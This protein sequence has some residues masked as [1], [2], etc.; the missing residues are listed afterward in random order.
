MSGK[1]TDEMV[2]RFLSWPLPK[3]FAPDCGITFKPINHP[4][5]W[6][7]GTNLFTADQARQMLEHVLSVVSENRSSVSISL[8]G[9]VTMPRAEDAAKLEEIVFW[10]QKNIDCLTDEHHQSEQDQRIL[11]L[12]IG[13][14]NMAVCYLSALPHSSADAKDDHAK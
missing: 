3:S 9:P 6:P 1:V 14:C 12:T 10:R 5:V 7:I 4:N 2:N 8:P 13:I 11:R